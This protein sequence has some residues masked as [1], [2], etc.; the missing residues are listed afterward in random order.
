[1][2]GPKLAVPSVSAPEKSSPK[3]RGLAAEKLGA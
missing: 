1:M 3:R 2:N